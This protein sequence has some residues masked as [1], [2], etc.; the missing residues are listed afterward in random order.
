[1]YWVMNDSLGNDS[2]KA[3]RDSSIGQGMI[4]VQLSQNLPACVDHIYFD[5][6]SRFSSFRPNVSLHVSC[7]L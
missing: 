1:M 6:F 2:L 4:L 7:Y 5:T 3:C